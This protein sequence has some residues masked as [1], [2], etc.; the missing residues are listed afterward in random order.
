MEG[1]GLDMEQKA[2]IILKNVTKTFGP[3]KAL[4]NVTLSVMEGQSMAL[5]GKNGAGK[6]T[7]ISLLTNLD[8]P[9]SGEILVVND[10]DNSE[11]NEIGCVYQRSSLTPY[12]TAAENIA[13][14]NFSKNKLGLISWAKVQAR[15]EDLLEEWGF[16]HIAEV[17]V[18]DLEPL[19]KKIVE[20][21]RVISTGPRVLIL[22]EPT[23]GLDITSTEL[24]FERM[25]AAHRRGV[26]SIYI[27]HHLQEI[28]QVCDVVAVLRDGKLVEVSDISSHTIESLVSLMVGPETSVLPSAALEFLSLTRQLYS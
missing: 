17:Q 16:A 22:D 23:A 5:I 18:S 25:H 26:T 9:D 6:S 12:L 8:K 7:L 24:L 11:I 2:K 20:I 13:I 14:G 1:L 3:T 15:A 27:S 19:E 10:Q 4:D 21:C 28:F